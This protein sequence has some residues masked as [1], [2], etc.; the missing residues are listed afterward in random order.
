MNRAQKGIYDKYLVIK[1]VDD[2]VITDCFIL[3]PEKDPAAVI[4]M[5]AYA[6]ATKDRI[7]AND[8]YKWVGRPMQKPLTHDEFLAHITT[9]H[10]HV[11][12]PLYLDFHDNHEFDLDFAPRWR[13]VYNLSAIN[14]SEADKY[15]IKWRC[16]K[17]VPTPE[18]RKASPW[19]EDAQWKG[20]FPSSK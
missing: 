5:Q 6:A 16:W 15:G 4:A 12:Q 13:D 18:E 1:K 2:T 14:K 3:I 19:K 11:I 10:P 17:V 8:I 9:G 20:L 7:L